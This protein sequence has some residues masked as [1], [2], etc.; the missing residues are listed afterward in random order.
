[1]PNAL[2]PPARK[3]NTPEP[4]L[5]DGDSLM[6][7]VI[8]LTESDSDWEKPLF[9]P[10]SRADTTM[11]VQVD[12]GDDSDTGMD[13]SFFQPEPPPQ[14]R[15]LAPKPKPQP[16]QLNTASHSSAS[17]QRTRTGPPPLGMRRAPLLQPS[18]F[19][20]S[21][22][23]KGATV[24]RFKPPLLTNARGG[25][26]NKTV[27]GTKLAATASS[28][29]PS[30]NGGGKVA[31]GTKAAQESRDPDSSFDVSFD[32]DVDALEEAMKAYD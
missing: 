19:S 24:A 22:G 20:S 31:V 30:R 7:D 10:T 8:D 14:T 12:D 16:P 26:A 32:M 5:P 17:T 6:Q 18:Q 4:T 13:V 21:Q 23:S 11:C 28:K 25:T 15:A 9:A 29:P 27:S 1:M 2:P 3:T